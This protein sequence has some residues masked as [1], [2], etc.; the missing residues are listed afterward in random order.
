MK[1]LLL[2]LLTQISFAKEY[3][4]EGDAPFDIE[5]SIKNSNFDEYFDA[6]LKLLDFK[7]GKVLDHFKGFG[8]L[9]N[10]PGSS[11]YTFVELYKFNLFQATSRVSP[12]LNVLQETHEYWD[13]NRA[14]C[15]K[16]PSY[17]IKTSAEL[18]YLSKKYSF[19][20]KSL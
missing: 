1:L 19:T 16:F 8:E 7:T 13:C 11:Y 15:N 4:C 6:S 20:C 2:L 12:K 18:L 14:R 17:S 9:K 5:F 3:Q 10:I